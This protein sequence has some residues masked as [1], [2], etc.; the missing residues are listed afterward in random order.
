MNKCNKGGRGHKNPYE[1]THVRIP[2]PLKSVISSLSNDYKNYVSNTGS[3]VFDEVS[4][5]PSVSA[6]YLVIRDERVIYVGSTSCLGDRWN[7]NSLKHETIDSIA[8]I[9]CEDSKTLSLLEKAFIE[10]LKPEINL[11]DIGKDGGNRAD[12][13][14]SPLAEKKSHRSKVIRVPIEQAELIQSGKL[15]ELLAVIND[16]DEQVASASKTSPRWGR[17]RSMISEIK[18]VLNDK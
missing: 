12:S 18:S 9:Q 17:A 16:W 14:S 15:E 5:L 7:G 6:V 11:R 2:S 10:F 3:L 13:R 4:V 8:W 1:S